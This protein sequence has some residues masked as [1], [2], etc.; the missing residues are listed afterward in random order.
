MAKM[1][2]DA[3]KET[4]EKLCGSN[5]KQSIFLRKVRDEQRTQGGEKKAKVRPKPR[6]IQGKGA[7]S[8]LRNLLPKEKAVTKLRGKGQMETADQIP[9][10]KMHLKD[11]ATALSY[12][13]Q[14]RTLPNLFTFRLQLQAAAERCEVAFIKQGGDHNQKLRSAID[15]CSGYLKTYGKTGTRKKFRRR[16]P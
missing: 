8:R 10:T 2:R 13:P 7:R 16:I 4:T 9:R 11:I 1:R 15:V 3:D 12:L 6:Q 14:A 5:Q